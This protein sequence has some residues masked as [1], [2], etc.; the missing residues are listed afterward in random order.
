MK[1]WSKE[2]L[3]L[4]GIY[5]VLGTPFT[6]IENN[7]SEQVLTV[8]SLLFIVCIVMLCFNKTPKFITQ[9]ISKYPRFSYYLGSIG[10][11]PYFAIIIP[12]FLTISAFFIDYSDNTI[13]LCVNI[14]GYIIEFGIPVSLIIAFLLKKYKKTK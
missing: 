8:L 5:G 13:S 12:I 10:W 11:I 7:I 6:Y 9:T 14:I 2:A 1:L 4:W 3:V